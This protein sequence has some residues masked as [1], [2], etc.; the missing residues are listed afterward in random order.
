MTAQ[1]LLAQLAAMGSLPPWYRPFKR[2]RWLTCWMATTLAHVATMAVLEAL[3]DKRQQQLVRV[4][5]EEP[6]TN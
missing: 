3:R 4:V 6:T 1:S 5:H 2:R